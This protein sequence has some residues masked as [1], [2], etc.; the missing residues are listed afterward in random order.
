VPST[1]TP[2][3]DNKAESPM[4][5]LRFA[6]LSVFIDFLGLTIAIPVLPF[7]CRRL[8]I[9]DTEFGFLF[10]TFALASA[11]S[12]GIT[13]VLSDRF[14]RRPMLLLSMVG[15]SLGFLL[16][17]L[18]EPI[19]EL[20]DANPI[21]VLFVLRF[22]H[23][24]S[25]NSMPVAS[26]MVADCTTS[27]NRAK[28]IGLL[29]ATVG[30]AFTVGPGIG[31]IA[32]T[33][34]N[35]VIDDD[36]S[37]AFAYVFTCSAFFCF[38]GVIFAIF[39]L[40]ETR[41]AN[42]VPTSKQS[43]V[44]I[45]SWRSPVLP[46]ALCPILSMYCFATMQA[47]LGFLLQDVYI[48][49]DK[50]A[51]SALGG[52][53]FASGFVIAPVQGGLFKKFVKKIGLVRTATLGALLLGTGTFLVGVSAQNEWHLA[54]TVV[55]LLLVLMPGF[56]LLNP[57][58]SALGAEYAPP[59]RLGAVQGLLSS[60]QTFANAF[61]PVASCALYQIKIVYAWT[62]GAASAW[63]V[64][65]PL[66]VAALLW[67]RVKGSASPPPNADMASSTSQKEVDPIAEGESV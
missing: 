48:S 34:I 25:G 61:G 10:A 66:C 28:F 27:E 30:I 33:V 41:C 7:F 65:L 26:A 58:F 55:F 6:Y 40:P 51:S 2:D 56:A 19:A 23:G 3:V 12:Q 45:L 53:L 20:F 43:Q 24:L 11:V 1:A 62:A 4:K 64:I 63:L 47:T 38:V 5:K 13:G 49:N 9:T 52:I 67:A 37:S 46:L 35:A 14:G 16:L 59:G 15:S 22:L 21:R 50:H 29:G 57:S 32:L 54:L 60:S 31:A 17:G 39:R 42:P 44:S 36:G 8:G 18:T